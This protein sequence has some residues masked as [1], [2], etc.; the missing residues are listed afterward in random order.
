MVVKGGEA[1][2]RLDNPSGSE[3][4]LLVHLVVEDVLELEHFGDHVGCA[5]SAS[6]VRHLGHCGQDRVGSALRHLSALSVRVNGRGLRILMIL[7]V[8]IGVAASHLR[9]ISLMS[10]MGHRRLALQFSMRNQ[11]R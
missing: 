7:V 9:Q 4:E 6:M 11:V 8:W 10:A 2:L 3:G 1:R 5:T